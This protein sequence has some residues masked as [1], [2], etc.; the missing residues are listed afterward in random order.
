MPLEVNDVTIMS[1][2]RIITI[3]ADTDLYNFK[4]SGSRS[5]VSRCDATPTSQITRRSPSRVISRFRVYQGE[6]RG[7]EEGKRQRER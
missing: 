6:R 4:R 2:S 3:A 1:P 7:L 5:P